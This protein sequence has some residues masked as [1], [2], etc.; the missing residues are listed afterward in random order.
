MMRGR[1]AVYATFASYD[2]VAH[3]SGLMRADTLEALRKLDQ[4]FDRIGARAAVR[5]APVRDRG[6]VRSRADAGRDVQA[7]QRLRA[8]RARRALARQR[9]RGHRPRRRRRAGRDGAARRRR[10]H[11]PSVREARQ[12][13]RLRAAGHRH[14]LRQPRAR[15]SHVGEAAAVDGGDRRAP[16]GAASGAARPPA[17]RLGA[18]PLR[19]A[20]RGRPRR[21]RRQ[22]PRRGARRGRGPAGAVLADGGAAPAAHRRL[23]PRGRHHGRQLLRPARW[24]RA[25]PSRS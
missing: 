22:L 19:R 4:Q 17:H 5:P 3:H 14:G 8:R 11:R 2:E 25:V 6:A 12:G 10:G 24:T 7:A 16:S 21:R 15:L 18:R 9:P 13:R 20:R 23:R 1:P